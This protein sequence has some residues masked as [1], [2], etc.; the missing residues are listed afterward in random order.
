M[1]NARSGPGT[2]ALIV[3]SAALLSGAALPDPGPKD[4]VD[5]PPDF[6]LEPRE[7][8]VAVVIGIEK[9]RDIEAPST[10]SA[11]DAELMKGY[12]KALGFRESNIRLL[13]NDRATLTDLRKTIERWLPDNAKPDGKVFFYYSGHG[14]P[15]LS[16]PEHPRAFLLPY[17]GDASDLQSTGYPIERLYDKLGKLNA[18]EV[19]V[20]LDSC[21]SGAGG[22]SVLAKGARPLVSNIVPVGAI[23]AKMAVLT[24][25]QPNQIST[26]SP[27]K[28]HGVLTYRFLEALRGGQAGLVQIYKKIKPVVEDDAHSLGVAQSPSLMLGSATNTSSFALATDLDLALAKKK[29]EEAEKLE[30]ARK[31]EEAKH[32]AEAQRLIDE[33]KRMEEEKR[34]IAAA[35]EEA[36]RKHRAEVERL[37]RESDAKAERLRRE[38]EE[39]DRRQREEFEREKRRLEKQQKREEPTFVPP[40]F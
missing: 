15:D 40:T 26:S 20:V 29:K 37:Q 36:D 23:A 8:D 24:A 1:K 5:A 2:L 22:R 28:K 19:I 35:Q 27:D 33:A 17:D 25:T 9:Y 3:L 14:S 16:D 30:A 38:A 4:G 18:A 12:L 31:E 21:F 13:T 10:Y 6:G 32:A 11:G 7:H 34:R 39:R